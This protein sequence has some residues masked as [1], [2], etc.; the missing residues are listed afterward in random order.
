M[1]V[2]VPPGARTVETLK[3][4]VGGCAGLGLRRSRGAA[5][6]ALLTPVLTR[7]DSCA[8]TKNA[9]VATSLSSIKVCMIRTSVLPP[10]LA[11]T[12]G[13]R[14][15]NSSKALAEFSLLAPPLSVNVWPTAHSTK[16]RPF[17]IRTSPPWAP[18][19]GRSRYEEG[20]RP[21]RHHRREACAGHDDPAR[22]PTVCLRP[23]IT[24]A[25]VVGAIEPVKSW[26][27]PKSIWVAASAHD[28]KPA[29]L[30]TSA[31]MQG[32]VARTARRAT[33]AEWNPSARGASSPPP[34]S[35]SC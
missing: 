26:G 30:R 7:A 32:A 24:W 1:G 3:A 21:Q 33:F 19:T 6:P 13:L 10:V 17:A 8:S 5:G 23:K 2:R 35:P 9:S 29:H 22:H 16:T 12:W 31:V 27:D 11:G 25:V 28:V 34:C 14:P 18:D 15:V 20:P 4:Q